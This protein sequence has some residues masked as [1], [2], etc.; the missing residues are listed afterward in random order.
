MYRIRSS[1][2]DVIYMEFLSVLGRGDCMQFLQVSWHL[3]IS[4]PGENVQTVH[5][6]V[7]DHSRDGVFSIIHKGVIVC[8]VVERSDNETSDVIAK[9]VK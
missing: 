3:I 9:D 2:F 6:H 5:F 7:R 8:I 1:D 4:T